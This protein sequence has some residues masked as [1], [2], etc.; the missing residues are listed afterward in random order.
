MSSA[1]VNN[2]LDNEK[3]LFCIITRG[4]CR[5]SAHCF[6]L[7]ENLAP[8]LHDRQEICLYTGVWRR[9]EPNKK[10]S[11]YSPVDSIPFTCSRK[12][13]TAP[14]NRLSVVLWF[15][16]PLQNETIGISGQQ[17]QDDNFL[18]PAT[19]CNTGTEIIVDA[20]MEWIA[21]K[22]SGS[23]IFRLQW[24]RLSINTSLTI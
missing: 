21:F 24:R 16:H 1:V 13:E 10:L 19:D 12:R 18:A 15:R 23:D 4:R 9:P 7:T 20:S 2:T 14:E 6:M 8:M 22:S 5:I 11:N 3:N 17:Q